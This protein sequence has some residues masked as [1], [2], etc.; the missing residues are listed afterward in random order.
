MK[1]AIELLRMQRKMISDLQ[2]NHP[3]LKMIDNLIAHG[4]QLLT[5]KFYIQEALPTSEQIMLRE[6]FTSREKQVLKDDGATIFTL[7]GQ[8]I[9]EQKELQRNKGKNSFSYIAS[10]ESI[11]LDLPSA[12]IEVAFFPHP[13]RFM[14]PGSFGKDLQTQER[15]LKDDAKILSKRLGLGG[16]SEIISVE[17]ATLTELTFRYLNETGIWLFGK[18]YNYCFA[19]TQNPIKESSSFVANVGHAY[20][21]GLRVNGW[22]PERGLSLLGVVRLIVPTENK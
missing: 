22:D 8:T 17:A 9:L 7:T 11:L 16:I 19:R 10:N 14:L 21:G 18:D 4:Q 1:N 12:P 3:E 15:L 6:G 20:F 2:S 5:P 13:E